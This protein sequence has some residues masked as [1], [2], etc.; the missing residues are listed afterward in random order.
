MPSRDGTGPA[1]AGPRTGGQRGSC[2]TAK[3]TRL[4]LDGRGQGQGKRRKKVK[5]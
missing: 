4:P 5:K 1:G 2:A 3:P